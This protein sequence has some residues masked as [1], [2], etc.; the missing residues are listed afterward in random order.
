MLP[1]RLVP[2]RRTA[3]TLLGQFRF[4]RLQRALPCRTISTS[5]LTSLAYHPP[6]LYAGRRDAPVSFPQDAVIGSGFEAAPPKPKTR[7]TKAKLDLDREPDNSRLQLFTA[8]KIQLSP[9]FAPT[10]QAPSVKVPRNKSNVQEPESDLPSSDNGR[11]LRELVQRHFGVEEWD[12]YQ[13]TDEQVVQ[14][15]HAIQHEAAVGQIKDVVHLYGLLKS[16]IQA[17][18]GMIA[19]QRDAYPEEVRVEELQLP[20]T[21]D[22]FAALLDIA[23]EQGSTDNARAV[24]QDM[25][26]VQVDPTI[27]ELNKALEVAAKAKDELFA[28]EVMDQIATLP[29][30]DP[31]SATDP[32]PVEVPRLFFEGNDTNLPDFAG[33]FHPDYV[34]SWTPET[35]H[36]LI[37]LANA[38][39]NIE[40]AL[41]LLGLATARARQEGDYPASLQNWLLPE[42][43]DTLVHL[44]LQL[45]EPGLAYDVC[46]LCI[47]SGGDESLPSA[48]WLALLRAC[49]DLHFVRWD[50][51]D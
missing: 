22:L 39:N 49:A 1:I 26:Q 43:R 38:T 25:A 48:T 7:K 18:R 42:C 40:F 31:Q 34:H 12:A 36:A 28:V 29:L 50:T 45:R 2:P 15:V 41:C 5:A 3:T 8:K 32:T 30:P 44:L 46:R 13:A 16:T 17:R 19:Q 51:P 11:P 14:L 33:I 10:T 37:K 35:I 23:A 4:Q 20:V 21:R 6:R 24:L 9:R 47:A 27:F